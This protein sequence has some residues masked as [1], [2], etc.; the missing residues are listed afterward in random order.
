MSSAAIR[1]HCF[2]HNAFFNPLVVLEYITEASEFKV[3]YSRVQLPHE[4]FLL[5]DLPG[6][7]DEE[8]SI[9]AGSKEN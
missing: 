4:G 2:V 5:I 1:S 9:V 3:L 7:V 6:R 8:L